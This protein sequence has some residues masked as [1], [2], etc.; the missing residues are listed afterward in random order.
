MTF[1]RVLLFV[2]ASAVHVCVISLMSDVANAF[3]SMGSADDAVV[4]DSDF[5][6]PA[7]L[8]FFGAADASCSCFKAAA[9]TISSASRP[10][11]SENSFR[12]GGLFLSILGL[13]SKSMVMMALSESNWVTWV[14]SR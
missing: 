1:C 12:S 2:S 11:P 7:A 14:A 4:R 3:T 9:S 6:F 8:G 5:L 10:N 13:I